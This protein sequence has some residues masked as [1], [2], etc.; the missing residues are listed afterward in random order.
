MPI[1]TIPAENKPV[2]ERLRAG[3]NHFG[4]D[5]RGGK[6]EFAKR[7]LGDAKKAPMVTDWRK[8]RYLPGN[9]IMRAIA[10]DWSC[11][12]DWL[13]FGG[14]RRAGDSDCGREYACGS[15]PARTRRSSGISR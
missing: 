12:F 13:R 8:G 10:K 7:Y 4:Y 14:R 6:I 11:T 3:M 1:D 2:A 5:V 15:T 9:E